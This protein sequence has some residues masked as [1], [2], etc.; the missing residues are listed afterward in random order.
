MTDE[1][2]DV[3]NMPVPTN[4]NLAEVWRCVAA[5]V[6]DRPAVTCGDRTLT[7]AEMD[8]RIVRLANWLLSQGIGDGDHLGIY[9]EN[10]PEYLEAMFAAFTIGA[11]PVNINYRYVRRE[12]ADLL[13]RADVVAV[14]H[15]AKFT[16][17]L[18][19]V[20]S[21]LPDV[22]VR[23]SLGDDYESALAGASTERP[24]IALR[25]DA[26]YLIYTGGTTGMPKG[27]L[28]THEDAFFACI[29]GGDPMR[30]QGPVGSP[31]ELMERIVDFEFT[32]MP[33]AP[34]MHAAAQWTGISWL[35]CGA[36]VV[37]LPGT[38]DPL[39]VWQTVAAEKVSSLVIVGDAMARPLMDTWDSDGPFDVSGLYS[40]GSGGAP[41][42]PTLRDRIVTAL[43]NIMLADGFGSS[44]TGAQGGQR[45]QPGERAEGLTRF[46]P[47]GDGTTVL[48]DDL[49]PVTPG[50]DEIGRVALTGRIPLGY[51]GDPDATART[52]VEHDG[53]RW[54][55]TGDAAQVAEDG[56]IV[57]LGRGGSSINTG[58]EKVF[59][60]EV[61][62]ALKAHPAVFD[63]IVVGVPDERWGQAVAA[64]V[65]P[66]PGHEIDLE[67]LV[68]HC[69]PLLAGY[70]IPR[71][72]RLVDEVRRSP[73][74][75]ADLRW[76][77]QVAQDS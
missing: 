2:G 66:A 7:Y 27:V 19:E 24:G 62:A 30:L 54:V 3:V 35:F 73:A 20:L 28:W 44:E 77:A 5:R 49:R 17:G 38:F 75:K 29:G 42:S 52:F 74:G 55:L 71:H 23:L 32:Q 57:L 46:T 63:C 60:E 59:P 10:A 51:Y 22:R 68:E 11:V 14:I 26:R 41:L 72:L 76:A 18:A 34:L 31:D 15:D 50:T 61:E 48:D 4:F 56:T 39:R 67:V 16:Q 12:L 45:I 40:I 8:E 58:G 33:L 6:P 65:Q 13:G 21:E 36:R 43:P 9:M 70:K 69:R 25:P 53:R 64:V 47:M 1:T 37:L